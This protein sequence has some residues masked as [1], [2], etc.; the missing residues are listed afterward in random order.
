MIYFPYFLECCNNH[1]MDEKEQLTIVKKIYDKGGINVRNIDMENL[2]AKLLYAA[3]QNAEHY[4]KTASQYDDA[5][6]RFVIAD[7]LE[8]KYID[9]MIEE[10]DRVD[11]I[12]I[13]NIM[14]IFKSV[15]NDKK[16]LMKIQ[17]RIEDI[18]DEIEDKLFYK[19]K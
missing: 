9:P 16:T 5:V 17:E 10:I 8:Y 19:K 4:D 15:I 3:R 13:D 6:D 7:K 2:Y 18:I 14:S 11:E 1:K 12:I